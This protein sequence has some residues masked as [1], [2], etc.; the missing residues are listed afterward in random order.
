MQ[1]IGIDVSKS[2]LD[3][4]ARPSGHTARFDNDDQG[5]KAL[6]RW[7]AG[8][9]SLGPCHLILEPTGGYERSLLRALLEHKLAFSVVNA[10]QIRD[11]ARASGRLAKTDRLDAQAI[12]HFGEALKPLP[13]VALD[14][15]TQELEALL[16]RRRQLVDMRVM[17]QNRRPLARRSIRP[18]LEA[19]IGF[20]SE[21]LEQLDQELDDHIRHSPHWREHE[22]LLKSVPG[23]GPITA[24]TMMTML[25]ELGKLSRKQIAA[26]VGVAPVAHDSGTHRGSRHIRGG[27]AA[28][29]HV[30]Y[31]AAVSS[32]RHNPVLQALYERLR[33]AGKQ[34]KVALVACMRKL[35]T[36]LNALVRDQKPWL[37]PQT[38]A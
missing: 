17:E 5:H 6:C 29:R 8:L 30:L 12:A 27:R 35:L 4:A 37:K 33:A 20:L 23:V 26:L 14:E 28:V 16:V 18:R 19:S 15:A 21:Q 24:R 10:R 36:I 2:H 25:P 1:W 31:M 9:A 22:D 11:F 38:N 7:V 3:L 13:T 32:S 34:A